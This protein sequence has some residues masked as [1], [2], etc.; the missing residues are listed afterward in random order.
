MSWF[1]PLMLPRELLSHSGDEM[2]LLRYD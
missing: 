1:S 2:C